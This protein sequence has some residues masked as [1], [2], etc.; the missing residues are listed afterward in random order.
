M[1]TS[2]ATQRSGFYGGGMGN[3]A[4]I[5]PPA[6]RFDPSQLNVQPR[7]GYMN[8]PGYSPFLLDQDR[9]RFI[10]H[11]PRSGVAGNPFGPAFQIPGKKPGGQPVL[12]GENKKDV[13]DVYGRPGMKQMPG[14]SPF[15][16]PSAMGA[17]GMMQRGN[18]ASMGNI[19][20]AG[21]FMGPQM[22][23]GIPPGY[24]NKFVS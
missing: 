15:Q 23:Q 3:E 11:D 17:P 7:P 2:Y 12:P 14:F 20:N 10:L 18:M 8:M 19:G 24:G 9:T 1:T 21:F 4:A 16:L 13:E 22:G 5:N 6:V